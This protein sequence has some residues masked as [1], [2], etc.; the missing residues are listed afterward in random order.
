MTIL[1]KLVF[2][3]DLMFIK[4]L[5]EF[6]CNSRQADSNVC[7]DI[8]TLDK[9]DIIKHKN[10]SDLHSRVKCMYKQQALAITV[11]ESLP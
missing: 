6:F 1:P 8:Q 4:I 10:V 7:E 11:T 5:R 9:W 3:S 2:R